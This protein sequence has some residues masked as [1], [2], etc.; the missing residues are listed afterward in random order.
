MQTRLPFV[1]ALIAILSLTA[2]LQGQ[3]A[4][5]PSAP[6]PSATPPPKV[7]EETIALPE[8]TVSESAG[9][10]YNAVDSL[11]ATRVRSALIDTPVTINVLTR[12]F[13]DDIGAQSIYDAA[14]YI[15]G[16]SQGRLA[17]DGGIL[18]RQTIRGFE[19]N[20]RIIDNFLT[21]F[22]GQF[23]PDDIERIE[24]VKGPSA[25]LS[26]SGS[27]GGSVNII[28]KS[29][30]FENQSAIS[31][32]V[33]NLFGQQGTFD[34]TGPI[35][36]RLAYR[37]TGAVMDAESY[38]P[39]K[40]QRW[41]VNPSL[42]FRITPATTLVIKGNFLSMRWVGGAS[43][44][45]TELIA[46]DNITGG[47]TMPSTPPPGFGYHANNTVPNWATRSDTVERIAT[48]LT[49][50][51]GS[52]IKVRLGVTY[53]YDKFLLDGGQQGLSISASRYNPYTGIYTPDETWAKNSAGTY[54]PTVS[55][56]YDPTKIPE[57]A[58][59]NPNWT[60]DFVVQN[61][62]AG[63]FKAGPVSLQPVVGGYYE[64]SALASFSKTAALP[65][66]NL[67]APDNDPV[68]PPLSAYNAGGPSVNYANQGDAYAVM[69]SGFFGD[70][71]FITGGATRYWANNAQTKFNAP[72]TANG[73]GIL[74]GNHD[75]YLGGGLFKLT[76][77]A[78]VYYSYMSNSAPNNSFTALGIPVWQSGKQQ[79][80]GIKTEW[81]DDRLMVEA[82]HYQISQSNLSTPNPAALQPGQPGTIL[83]D[84]TNHGYEFQVT[85]RL[86]RNVTLFLGGVKMAD[87]DAFGRRPRNIADRIV[88]GLVKYDFREGLL[89]HAS[90]FVGVDHTGDSAG[91]L[92]QGTITPLGVLQQVSFY[93]PQRTIV[94]AGASYRIGKYRFNLNVNNLLDQR[95]ISQAAGRY[96]LTPFPTT[97]VMFTTT[98]SM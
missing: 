21:G 44:P 9:N 26:P 56:S 11:S 74:K 75:S 14:Q 43:N 52:R 8:F 91:E 69:R 84:Q 70:R 38:V 73:Y 53:L 6:P 3:S 24:I 82:S 40:V 22:Q 12:E 35:T 16:V 59:I 34:R 97:Q 33:A 96:S 2:S 57:T 37:I 4:P 72:G 77:S 5:P 51:I 15:S 1:T 47:A 93:V 10:P 86:T 79:Q 49:H 63:T 31:A 42:L 30:Q 48:E 94:N 32:T 92:P 87:R 13:L 27:P 20:G 68:H 81:F 76:K 71:L 25:I 61:D 90:V 67:F 18:D 45:G 17:G 64:W 41:D 29:P 95:L 50:A 28:T 85:G 54:L 19:S 89:N 88:R 66:V 23:P 83:T 78:S 36:P 62:W 46:G 58:N 7:A 65:S 98:L 39:G 80:F 55:P 60:H